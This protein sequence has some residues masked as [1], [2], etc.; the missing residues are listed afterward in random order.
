MLDIHGVR[1]KEDTLEALRLV[2]SM[3]IRR[4]GSQ[5]INIS[6]PFIKAVQNAYTT[7]IQY[8]QEKAKQVI[9]AEDAAKAAVAASE[10]MSANAE[11]PA[12]Q[13]AIRSQIASLHSKIRVSTDLITESQQALSDLM[14]IP[15]TKDNNQLAD[16]SNKLALG[17]KR[18]ADCEAA[19][20][21][22]TK[23]SK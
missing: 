5:H 2:K 6:R 10:Q 15:G 13:A 12:A 9:A 20:A 17:V 11:E 16:I 22:L 18:K 3:I 21:E 7:H 23:K 4:G 14:K 8:G 1:T 19:L